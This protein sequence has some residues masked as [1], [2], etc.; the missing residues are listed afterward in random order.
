MSQ[1]FR[2]VTSADVNAELQRIIEERLLAELATRQPGHC[3]RVGDLDTSVMLAVAR[4]LRQAVVP[5]PRYMFSL[6]DA[7]R[8]SL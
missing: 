8:D 1:D 5:P 2:R 3:M 7:Q 4:A 6:R